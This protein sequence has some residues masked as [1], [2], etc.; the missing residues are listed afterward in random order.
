MA[1]NI[2]RSHAGL[3]ASAPPQPGEVPLSIKLRVVSGCFHRE[4]SPHAYQLID[5]HLN[6]SPAELEFQEHESGPELLVY[7]A[8]VLARCYAGKERHR[9][10]HGH[11]QG[12][13][14]R[15]EKGR[16]PERSS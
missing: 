13:I 7:M 15:R 11:H 9:P 1:T 5:S 14:R 6:A 2:S 16:P 8:A 10:D 12:Q 3:R 4:H